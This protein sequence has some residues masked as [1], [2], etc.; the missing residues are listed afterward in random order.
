MWCPDKVEKCD[1]RRMGVQNLHVGCRSPGFKKG[2]LVHMF[3]Q[4]SISDS[5]VLQKVVVLHHLILLD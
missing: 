3:C 1:S 2:E 4:Y 5:Q